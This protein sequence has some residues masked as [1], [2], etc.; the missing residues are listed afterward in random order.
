MKVL[1]TGL[2]AATVLFSTALVNAQTA[3][4]IISKHLTAIGGKEKI[5]QIKSIYMEGSMEIMGNE[6]PM[7]TYLLNGKGF[8]SEVEF[9]GQKI[10]NAMNEKGGWMINPMMG[11]TSPQPLP[12]EQFEAGKDQ[13]VIGGALL[14]YQTNGEKAELVGKEKLNNV[15]AYKI[16]LTAK[17]SNATTYFIDANTYYI[18]KMIKVANMAG[19]EAE[20]ETSFSDYKPTDY[21]YIVPFKVEITLPQ[22]F[23]L[24][25]NMKKV[26]VNKEIDPKIFEMPAN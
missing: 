2:L 17:D 11:S 15:D 23:S 4:E 22:G 25:T 19:Q 5:N 26:E 6:A 7:T 14:T 9:N 1:K 20:V 10:V 21:G 3:D 16:K 13:M 12:Q 24:A 8:K 18:L